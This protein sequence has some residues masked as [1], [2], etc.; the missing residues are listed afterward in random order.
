MVQLPGYTGLITNLSFLSYSEVGTYAYA[1][2][3]RNIL[4][5]AGTEKT[6]TFLFLERRLDTGL[7]VL[8]AP[9]FFKKFKFPSLNRDATGV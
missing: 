9:K 7:S 2:Y 3:I 4:K 5:K 6:L 1:K 8:L